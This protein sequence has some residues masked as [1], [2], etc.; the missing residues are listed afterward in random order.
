M[1]ISK[2]IRVGSFY[3]F[4]S[5]IASFIILLLWLNSYFGDIE[6][7]L[8]IDDLSFSVEVRDE[9]NKILHILLANDERYRLKTQVKDVDPNYLKI[10]LNYE[11]KRFYQH[12]G[13]DW[14]STVRAS[15]QNLK[16][17]TI[18][19]GAST[20]SMQV[21]GLLDRRTPTIKN[22]LIEM[23]QAIALEKKLDKEQILNLY[24]S[25]APFGSNV[26][27]VQA[28]SLFWF[29]KDSLSL[30]PSEAALLVALPQSPE[31]RRPDRFVDAAIQARNKV[32][33]RAHDN[34][35][36]STDFMTASTL[37][38]INQ[39]PFKMPKHAPHLA[40]ACQSKSLQ[41]RSSTLNF[42]L[43]TQINKL[44]QN[45]LISTNKN[46]AAI[47]ADAS[48]GKIK[49]YIGSQNYVDHQ[50]LGAND[51]ALAKR[52]YGSTLK[53]FIYAMA[54]DEGNMSFDSK[55]KDQASAFSDYQPLNLSNSFSGEINIAQALQASLNIPAVVSLKTIGVDNFKT[56]LQLA[57]INIKNGEGLALAL[58]GGGLSLWELVSLYTSL[59]NNGSAVELSFLQNKTNNKMKLF[60]V[61]TIHQLNTILSQASRGPN[62]VS[63]HIVSDDIAVK[64]G[65]GPRYSDAWAIGNSGRY[66]VG[67]WLG[68]PTGDGLAN[69]LGARHA[70]PVLTKIFSSLKRGKLNKTPIKTSETRRNSISQKQEAISIIY[71]QND[72]IIE[73][74]SLPSRLR[75]KL[76]NIEYPLTVFQNQTSSIQLQ[77]EKDFI[78]LDKP[79]G[80]HFLFIDNK[81]ASA[82]TYVYLKQL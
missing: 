45:T 75:P 81:G 62:R 5:L 76:S 10:L 64:T 49:A 29:G 82:Q 50:R 34:D 13:V 7:D 70:L 40:Y 18:V 31:K 4:M 27:S 14:L 8:G 59:S 43:Q 53:P 15:I 57:N 63:A 3:V 19:S 78:R 33:Q 61:D 38:R 41:C 55:I 30:T 74:V 47:V 66:V 37:S 20:I 2:S 25:I 79:G 54:V 17:Q 42:Q 48:T 32:L 67:V 36:I 11:D 16:K 68:S 60:E 72:T 71:P 46:I 22:K 28:A 6:R 77:S 21:V 56:R 52:S 9:N 1:T 58:G 12:K 24:L 69:N 44:I 65:T 51:Y 39:T 26:E 80:Y 73:T 35:L 23:R